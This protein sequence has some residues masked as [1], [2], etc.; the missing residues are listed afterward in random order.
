[1]YRIGHAVSRAVPTERLYLLSLGSQQAVAHVHWHVAPLPPGRP[2]EHQQYASLMHEN[3]YLQIPDR[4]QR[5]LAERIRQE[6]NE[7]AHPTLDR[8]RGDQ[9]I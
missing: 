2:Y 8:V 5:M 9:R 4:E 1:V 3:G 6:I 7:R